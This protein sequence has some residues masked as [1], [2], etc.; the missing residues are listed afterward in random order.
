[1]QEAGLVHVWWK[2]FSAD[3]SYCLRKIDQEMNNR[4]DDVKKPLTLKGLSGS[5]IILCSGCFAS[6]IVFLFEFSF[7]KWIIGNRHIDCGAF[8]IICIQS[9]FK[10][11][12][13][14][15]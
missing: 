1:M 6:I 9:I 12:R 14:K 7:N 10:N 5:F 3:A 11:W 15:N 13:Q 4:K 2:E 8:K